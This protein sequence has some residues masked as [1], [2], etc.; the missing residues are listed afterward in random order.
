MEDGNIGLLAFLVGFFDKVVRLRL[1]RE[2]IGEVDDDILV[3]TF[4]TEEI[5]VGTSSRSVVSGLGRGALLEG[6]IVVEDVATHE[7]LDQLGLDREIL[8]TI[9]FLN[10]QRD[11]RNAIK[12]TCKVRKKKKNIKKN[13]T[14]ARPWC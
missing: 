4:S 10:L 7:S 12:D 8:S 2:A 11:E 5:K 3:Q 1:I 9:A 13:P 6:R 14:F